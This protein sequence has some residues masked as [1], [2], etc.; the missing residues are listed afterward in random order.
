MEHDPLV[1]IIVPV[2]G[3]QEYLP[4][5]IDSICTQSYKNIEII[6]VDD[7]SPDGCPEICD[8]YAEKDSRVIV[9]HQQN[10]GVSGAR[11]TGMDKANG[12]YVMF[13]DSDDVLEVNA[14][15]LLLQDIVRYKADIASASKTVFAADKIL[16]DASDDGSV[17]IYEGDEMIKRSLQYDHRTRALHS[18]LFTVE[19][20][21]DTRFVEGHNINEDSY[22]M[23]ECYAKLPKVVQHNVSVYRYFLRENSAS[24]G[25]FSDKYL[26]MLYFCDLKMSFI[27]ENMPHFMEQA[28]DMAV[29]TNLLFLDVLCRTEDK[30]YR[31]LQRECVRTV[32][33][34][35]KYHKPKSKHHMQLARIAA[36]GLY[37]VYKMLVRSKYYK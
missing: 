21:G 11:N 16:P 32:R 31:A 3:T 9:I 20:L 12:E 18:K 15:E 35:Y 27:S 4:A 37:P 29:R 30:K 17:H 2:Y 19:F 1:S 5:C 34:L 28:K 33:R 7:Q 6:L 22:F 13:V 10:K 26:D 8:S 24:R 36:C 25:K 23:F 14:V